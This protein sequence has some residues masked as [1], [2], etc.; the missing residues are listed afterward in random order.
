M[1]GARSGHEQPD[2][3]AAARGAPERRTYTARRHEVGAHDPG[4]LNAGVETPQHAVREHRTLPRFRERQPS[5]RARTRLARRW[6]RQLE[7]RSPAAPDARER[8]L[9]VGD[10]GALA[11]HHDL[12]PRRAAAQRCE[13]VGEPGATHEGRAA[14]GDQELAVIAQQIAEA[15][16][17]LERVE[18][19]QLPPGLEQAAAVGTG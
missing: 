19:A 14:I 17:Q 10:H 1:V 3:D 9:P 4:T 8:A 16:A 18:E 13:L 12:A 5:G 6:E 15:L 7:R 11:A 2:I